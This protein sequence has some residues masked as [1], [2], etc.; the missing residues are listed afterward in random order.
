MK[1]KVSIMSAIVFTMLCSCAIFVYD[2]NDDDGEKRNS[3]TS[4]DTVTII[5]FEKNNNPVLP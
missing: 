4:K 1:S 3:N 2:E 5:F